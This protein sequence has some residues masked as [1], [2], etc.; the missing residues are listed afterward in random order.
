MNINSNDKWFHKNNLM[1]PITIGFLE[2]VVGLGIFY[3]LAPTSEEERAP[4]S[5]YSYTKLVIFGFILLVMLVTNP[6][7]EDHRQAVMDEIEKKITGSQ[8]SNQ[9]EDV[10]SQIGMKI[11]ESIGKVVLDQAVERDNYLLF[12]VTILKL[13]N[14]KREVGIGI[15]GKVW[16]FEGDKKNLNV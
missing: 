13:N 1:D 14:S 9:S 16:I 2:I 5:D 10:W 3:F 15:F 8:A 4:D 7:V 6:S 11:G 12:S